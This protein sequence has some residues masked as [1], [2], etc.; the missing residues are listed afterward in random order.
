MEN[1]K[2]FLINLAIMLALSVAG[3]LFMTGVDIGG[4]RW[5]KFIGYVIFFASI[6]SPSILFSNSSCSIVSRLRRR[7]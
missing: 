2:R 7:S 1:H 3:A 5:V 6:F 4:T